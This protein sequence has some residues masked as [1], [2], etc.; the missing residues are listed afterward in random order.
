MEVCPITHR[1]RPPAARR[2]VSSD[3]ARSAGVRAFF[4]PTGATG[5]H[6]AKLAELLSFPLPCLPASFHGASAG[7]FA[8][9]GWREEGSAAG[10]AEAARPPVDPVDRDLRGVHRG[11]FALPLLPDAA[12]PLHRR[13]AGSMSDGLTSE[14]AASRNERPALWIRR[15]AGLAASLLL[16]TALYWTVRLAW[17]RLAVSQREC[18]IHPKGDPAGTGHSGILRWMGAG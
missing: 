1:S 9:G 4:V 5:W 14:F 7:R 11:F 18:T 3:S 16:A 2:A 6:F 15:A 13:L 17:S 10:G 8:A 12:R